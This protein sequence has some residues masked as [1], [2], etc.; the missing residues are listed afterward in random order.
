MMCFLATGAGATAGY[1]AG[2]WIVQLAP[3]VVS[4]VTFGIAYFNARSARDAKNDPMKI[5]AA[6]K[7]GEDGRIAD[8]VLTRF[9]SLTNLLQLM[10]QRFP[11]DPG[12]QRE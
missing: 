2:D 1:T 8:S 6:A 9:D 10:L 7:L 4:V 11:G 5:A 12:A 3:V